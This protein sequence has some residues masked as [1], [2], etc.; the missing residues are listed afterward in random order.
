MIAEMRTYLQTV[1]P[2][3]TFLGHEAQDGYEAFVVV[4]GEPMGSYAK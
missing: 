1:F 2:A 3:M 4:Q